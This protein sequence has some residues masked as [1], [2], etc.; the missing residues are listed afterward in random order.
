[1]PAGHS[2]Q[3]EDLQGYDQTAHCQAV[4]PSSLHPLSHNLLCK[5]KENCCSQCVQTAAGNSQCR[6]T[7]QMISYSDEGQRRECEEIT[8]SHTN[9]TPAEKSFRAVLSSSDD[10]LMDAT[11]GAKYPSPRAPSDLGESSSL[12]STFSW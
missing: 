3:I 5:I 6:C 9:H 4:S 12:P 7:M 1:M 11:D 2:T 10:T 8:I